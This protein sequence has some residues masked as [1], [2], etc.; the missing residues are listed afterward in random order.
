[1]IDVTGVT[2]LL[3]RF[4]RI[5]VAGEAATVS[6]KEQLAQEIAATA[7]SLVPVETGTLR[8]S[9]T[10]EPGRVYTDVDYAPF[11]E[12][13]TSVDPAQ[14]FLRPA[15]DEANPDASL[16]VAADIIEHA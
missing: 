6:V 13:G 9:I 11:V 14:P 7:R 1:M 10:A 2:E 12:Y 4:T 15:A 8:D 5:E 16:R 3:A